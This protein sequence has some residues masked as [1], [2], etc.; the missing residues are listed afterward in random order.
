MPKRPAPCLHAL[1]F[2]SLKH[3]PVK[4]TC[5]QLLLDDTASIVKH[6]A[7]AAA[8]IRISWRDISALTREVAFN[9]WGIGRGLR[10]LHSKD[11]HSQA[12]RRLWPRNS[13]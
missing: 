1:G 8:T 6:R 5:T 13:Q 12:E 3:W 4:K 11:C 7:I 10:D 2:G 9:M